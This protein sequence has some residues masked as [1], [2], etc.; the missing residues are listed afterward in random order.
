MTHN[1]QVQVSYTWSKSMDYGSAGTVNETG[2]GTAMQY[3]DPFDL[4]P[5]YARSNFDRTHS[6]RVNGIVQLP[7]KGHWLIEGWQVSGILN[8]VS[9]YPF[10]VNDGF[11]R[12]G[13]APQLGLPERPN[14]VA[15]CKQVLGNPNQWFNPACYTIPGVGEL[16]NLGR[17]TVTGPNLVNTDIALTKNTK[18]PKLSEQF[19]IQFRA[20]IFNVFNHTSFALPFATGAFI[21]AATPTGAAPNPV[22]GAIA[23]TS[24][25]SRQIQFG[26]KLMF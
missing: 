26:L 1:A 21:S 16:G 3:Q 5:D 2:F 13:L 19:A 15:G 18:I 17:N 12:A 9:G 14:Y 23:A 4:K 8:A 7:L 25:T 24:T 11:D 10:T 22:G 6:L 20:E